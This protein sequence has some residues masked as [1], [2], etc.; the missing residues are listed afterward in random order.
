MGSTT[1]SAIDQMAKAFADAEAKILEMMVTLWTKSRTPTL[2]GRTDPGGG[3]SP[4]AWLQSHTYYLVG[5]VAVLGVLLAA[6]RLAWQ[7]RGEPARDVASGLLTLVVVTWCGSAAVTLAVVAG[8]GYSD[9]IIAQAFGGTDQFAGELTR[10]SSLAGTKLAPGLVI[11]V[12]LCAILSCLVQMGLMLVRVAM[13]G[14]LTGFLPIAGAAALTPEGRRMWR[15]ML[16]WLIAFVLYKPVAATIYAFSIKSIQNPSEL[17]QL[18]GIIMIIMAVAALPAL[19]RFV[20]PM[21]SVTPGKGSAAGV[22]GV[23]TG[24]AMGARLVP[25]LSGTAGAAGRGPGKAGP[26]PEGSKTPGPGQAGPGQGGQNA[27][28]QPAGRPGQLPLSENRT[29]P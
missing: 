29:V 28:S 12:A 15:R 23:A 22:G 21:V 9:W 20:V 18:T 14:L 16:G 10:M 27:G 4:V 19:M 7:R 17:S 1:G 13:L 11:V 6:G 24:T 3:G 2:S 25:S 8:D 26:W 5:F